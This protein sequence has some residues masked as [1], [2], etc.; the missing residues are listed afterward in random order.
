MVATAEWKVYTGSVGTENP[1]TGSATNI[2]LMAIDAY[3]ASGTDYTN[4]PIAVPAS[5]TNYSYERWVRIKFSG[6]FNNINNIKAWLDSWNKS[7]PNLELYAGV[8]D[9]Y[10][11][12]VN[13]RSTIATTPSANWTGLAN[14][15]D[16]TP[17]GG[18]TAS[19]GYSKYLVLQLAVP[20]TVTTPGDVGT[21]VVKVQYDES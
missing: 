1:S 21:I 13:T 12:P 18:I 7:D 20:S 15:L 9:T 2:N 16:L 3:D 14:A 4:Y 17:T 19:P 5:G 11:T 10:S 8:T 6:T